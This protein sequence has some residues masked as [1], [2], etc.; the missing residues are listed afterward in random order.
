MEEAG[1]QEGGDDSAAT[2]VKG[3][4]TG[5]DGGE[6]DSIVG[7]LAH[8]CDL[9]QAPRKELP[10]VG[11]SQASPIVLSPMLEGRGGRA[12]A[13]RRLAPIYSPKAKEGQPPAGK[14]R[15]RG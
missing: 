5:A 8:M 15:R 9:P 10:V 7:L 1:E 12:Q 3:E 4:A 2:P 13:K 14:R 6:D 11:T